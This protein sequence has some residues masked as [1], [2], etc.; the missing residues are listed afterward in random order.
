MET[1]LALKEGQA[2]QLAESVPDAVAQGKTNTAIR[3]EQLWKTLP[4]T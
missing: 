3:L 2:K 1:K 4:T